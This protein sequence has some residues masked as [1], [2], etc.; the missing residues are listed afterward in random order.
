MNV[1]LFGSTSSP[2]CANFA[3]KQTAIDCNGQFDQSGVDAVLRNLYVDDCLKSDE[4]VKQ[5]TTL[6]QDLNSLLKAG[7]FTILKWISDSKAEMSS[8]P[9]AEQA[10]KM[11]DLDLDQDSLPVERALGLNWCAETDGFFLLFSGY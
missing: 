1:H 4:T 2:S 10:K 3:L 9:V 11:I 6:I 5:A 7:G 8:I